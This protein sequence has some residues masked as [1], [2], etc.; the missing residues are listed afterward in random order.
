MER[1]HQNPYPPNPYLTVG[2]NTELAC[3]YNINSN[4]F[5]PLHF[6]SQPFCS[7]HSMGPSGEG[8]IFSGGQGCLTRLWSGMCSPLP[9][10]SQLL[11]PLLCLNPPPYG[12]QAI[13]SIKMLTYPMVCWMCAATQEAVSAQVASC[14]SAGK[15]CEILLTSTAACQIMQ[16]AYSPCKSLL[17]SPAARRWYAGAVVLQDGRIFVAGGSHGEGGGYVSPVS[18]WGCRPSVCCCCWRSS[19]HLTGIGCGSSHE[20]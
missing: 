2:G 18:M 4:T 3:V 20:P 15:Q 5:T 1:P 10:T 7:G 9:A 8:W 16:G 11:P 6:T 13:M 19:Q 14:Q 12:A 17:D